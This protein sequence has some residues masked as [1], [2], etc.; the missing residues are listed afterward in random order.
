M[1]LPDDDFNAE[2]F[3]ALT[4]TLLETPLSEAEEL[5]MEALDE[6]L[7]EA[8]TRLP[9][10]EQKILTMTYWLDMSA[11]EIAEELNMTTEAVWASLSRS[12]KALKKYLEEKE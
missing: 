9:E 11:G 1:I 10:R 7:R 3:A 6:A 5:A 2:E 4:K 12:R 8:L